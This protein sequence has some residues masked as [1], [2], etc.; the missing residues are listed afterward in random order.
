MKKR[1]LV[2]DGQELMRYGLQ[3]ALSQNVIE[4]DT[5][6]TA[7]EAQEALRS[8]T[9]DLC[10]IDIFLPDESGLQLMESIRATCPKMKI[11]MMTSSDSDLGD[12]L[13]EK[14][15]NAREK[16]ACH[17]L[18][19]PFDLS[20]L[21]DVIFRVLQENSDD[22][23]ISWFEEN[24]AIISRRRVERKKMSQK[25]D[26]CVSIINDGEVKRKTFTA[27]TV[28]ISDDGIGLLSPYPLKA[29]DVLSFDENVGRKSGVVVWSSMFNGQQCK[30]GIRF[31]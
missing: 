28:D 5:V 11:I 13:N 21:K 15:N 12:D 8:C 18:C 23:T 4:V 17:F 3:K 14:I 9:Y 16:K 24:F 26:F 27:E 2:I 19:K 30:T 20:Q 25:I 1:I 7:G 31:A 10:L 6:G 29:S 22:E